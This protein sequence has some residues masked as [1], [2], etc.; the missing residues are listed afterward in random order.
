[1]KTFCKAMTFSTALVV[2]TGCGIQGKW[3]VDH[4]EPA[5]A[6]G[7][8]KIASVEL[9]KGGDYTATA[10]EGETELESSGRWEFSEGKLTL[11]PSQEGAGTRVY[12]AALKDFGRSLHV[13]AKEGDEEVTAV[14]KRD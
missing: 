14:M 12:D 4:V 1:M 8:F 13:T 11:I 9:M 2:L 6:A 7:D 3:T 5:D 10:T